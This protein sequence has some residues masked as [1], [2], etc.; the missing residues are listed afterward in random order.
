MSTTIEKNEIEKGTKTNLDALREKLRMAKESKEEKFV[1]EEDLIAEAVEMVRGNKR[2]NQNFL[3]KEKDFNKNG[4]ATE[5]KPR[6]YHDNEKQIEDEKSELLK[7][8]M[9]ECAAQLQQYT[10]ARD[11]AQEAL[12]DEHISAEDKEEI[13]KL[14]DEM[15]PS[16]DQEIDNLDKLTKE[17]EQQKTDKLNNNEKRQKIDND[18]KH[19]SYQPEILAAKTVLEVYKNSGKLIN[20]NGKSDSDF[21]N[22]FF[23]KV[24]QGVKDA[25]QKEYREEQ[26][27]KRKEQEE[28]Q[29]KKEE[30]ADLGLDKWKMES[31]VLY[32]KYKT[33]FD[34]EMEKIKADFDKVL[35]TLP[36]E[37]SP[38]KVQE[39]KNTITKELNKKDAFST[40]IFGWTG[41]KLEEAKNNLR[42]INQERWGIVKSLSDTLDA[43]NRKMRII[44]NEL[45]SVRGSLSDEV[46]EDVQECEKLW[47]LNLLN[48]SYT[49]RLEIEKNDEEASRLKKEA[50]NKMREI[51][52]II[53]KFAN[54]PID[55]I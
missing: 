49:K 32:N 27:K 17:F 7:K 14:I 53:Q 54:D 13:Q 25:E 20:K 43:S 30:A 4:E 45:F 50:E 37:L 18:Q 9:G 44:I 51:R 16:I 31:E 55:T 47:S 6:G 38:K 22:A 35:A 28:E 2:L 52:E 42:K 12:E 11:E 26:N 33:E 39:L 23:D 3:Q 8:L 48:A 5:V 10:N 46:P 15:K 36:E 34:Q 21:E 19:A 1:K 29:K 40:K 24:E 41:A